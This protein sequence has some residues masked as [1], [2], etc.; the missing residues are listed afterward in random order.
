[1]TRDFTSQNYSSTWFRKEGYIFQSRMFAPCKRDGRPVRS[2]TSTVLLWLYDWPDCY[3]SV[4]YSFN[5]IVRAFWRLA[6]WSPRRPWPACGSRGLRPLCP[7]VLPHGRSMPAA[8][9]DSV[10][11]LGYLK[12]VRCSGLSGWLVKSAQHHEEIH[13]PRQRGRNLTMPLVSLR[14]CICVGYIT[15][16]AINI[17]LGNHYMSF[18]HRIWDPFQKQSFFCFQLIQKCMGIFLEA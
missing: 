6:S 7:E 11:F 3:Y 8:I 10:E 4:E 12:V 13:S 18:N 9:H 5:L 17:S 1:M 2:Y 15:W 14:S 16:S